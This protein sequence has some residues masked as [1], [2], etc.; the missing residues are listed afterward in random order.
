MA[1]TAPHRPTGVPAVLVLRALGLGDAL[2]GVPALR[3]LRRRFAGHPLVLAADGPP[4]ALLRTC[5]VVDAVVPTRGLDAPPPGPRLPAVAG[6]GRTRHL[7]VNLHGRG[8][9]SHRLLLAGNPLTLLCFA[10]PEEPSVGGPRWD[11]TEHEVRRWCRLVGHAGGRCDP[12][13]LRL[14]MPPVRAPLPVAGGHV[15]VHPGAA[16]G[17]RR[18]PAPRWAAVARWLAAQ[19]R[20]VVLTGGPDEQALAATVAAGAGLAPSASL[21]GRLS[22]P[23]LCVLVGSAALVCCGDTGVAHLATAFGTP[24]VRLFGPT[25]PTLWGPLSDPGHHAVLWYPNT[26]GDPHGE[27][28]DP[29][30]LRIDVAEVIAATRVLLA[31]GSWVG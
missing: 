31:G 11:P 7:A 2:T 15:V 9:T 27:R 29:A 6:P 23:E 17:S 3:G 16:S 24:S 22:L 30:L 28:P 26:S 1:L 25:P 14:P 20:R 21:A 18:W 13:D 12:T 10:N 5:G 4:A 8:P 19:G